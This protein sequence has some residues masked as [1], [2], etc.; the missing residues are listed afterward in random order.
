M[1]APLY[2]PDDILEPAMNGQPA[3]TAWKAMMTPCRTREE[4]RTWM[5]LFLGLDPPDT[6][7]DTDSNSNPVDM[8]WK[9]YSNCL[10]WNELPPEKRESK[11]LF[12]ASRDCFKTLVAA[13]VEFMIVIHDHRGV[14]HTAATILQARKAY[15]QYF[16]RFLKRP[17]FR[18]FLDGDEKLG[19]PK[20]LKDTSAQ[21]TLGDYTNIQ[22]IPVTKQAVQ[23]QHEALLCRDEIDVVED[24]AAYNDLDGI[25]SSMPDKRPPID[26]GISV[27][28]SAFGLVQ[29]E[30]EAMESGV[31]EGKVYHWNVID[32]TERCPD[33]RSGV[34]PITLYIRDNSM[35]Y[36]NQEEF[37][38]L[39]EGTKRKYQAY[40]AFQGCYDNCDVF[41]A[42]MTKLKHQTSTSSWLKPIDDYLTKKLKST[43][44]SMFIA[45]YL[46]RKPPSE[47]LV[48]SRFDEK[49]VKTYAQMYETFTGKP[50]PKSRMTVDELVAVFKEHNVPC[51]AGV[52]WG[53][54]DASTCV[55][56]F[57]DSNDNVYVVYSLWRTQTDNAEFIRLI[58]ETVHERFG[59]EMYYPD[60]SN[61]S[62]IKM[63]RD[64]PNELPVSK[65][66]DKTAN[67]IY[68]GVQ[69]MKRFITQPGT[70][71]GK[72]FVAQN[73]EDTYCADVI[74]EFGKYHHK[75]DPSTGRPDDTQFE[76]RDN[77]RMDAI[78]YVLNT[79]YGKMKT[80]LVVA[81]ENDKPAN[82][83]GT[84]RTISGQ[85]TKPPSPVELARHLGIREFKDN[86]NDFD[87]RGVRRKKK[88]EDDGK[89]GGGG[90]FSWSF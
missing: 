70:N 90:E 27:R 2:K 49:N 65:R 1:S 42:C 22:I 23:S 55:V 66:V 64:E 31:R 52:D 85:F 25:P 28:K 54:T 80:R 37:N 60:S 50:A 24:L 81:S 3:L 43:E 84:N 73:P 67:S 36:I 5:W 38:K 9:V 6:T 69:E 56:M 71:A 59:V 89:T 32:C 78:R 41:A 29:R 72:F 39:D 21:L 35:H 75:N 40:P 77:H 83:P 48:F 53:F 15:E 8:A 19:V 10:W 74:Y 17:I 20:I 58:K 47:G 4:M 46:S 86:S 61:P 26:F 79:R 57:I 12:F 62:G 33:E 14:V 34:N 76:D 44:E 13:A 63:M 68:D 88:D 82:A 45:S 11:M 16:K 51:F 7:V 30:I 18:P 87:E